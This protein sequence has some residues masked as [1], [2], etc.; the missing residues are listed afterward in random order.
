MKTLCYKEAIMKDKQRI[1]IKVGT[2]TLTYENGKANLRKVEKLCKVISDLENQGHEMVLVSSG[3]LGVGMGK[4][5]ITTRPT[6]TNKKQAI[7]AVGQCE[8]MFMY[9]KFFDE[10]NNVVS[11]ILLTKYVVETPHKEETVRN[12]FMSLI[13]M[14]IIPIVNEND[15]VA[16]DELEGNKIG[17][18]DQ[19]SAIVA[20]IIN[21]DKLIILTDIDGLYDKNPAT[22]SD[23]KKIN[24][25]EL[26]TDEIKAMAG[27]RGSSRGTGGMATKILAAEIATEVGIDVQ[28]ISGEN[29]E[30]IYDVFEG[31]PVGTIFMGKEKDNDCN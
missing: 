6:E 30:T 10:Y 25:V 21:A 2:S 31:K 22:N 3:A 16:T 18:N 28:I 26:I 11:Q 15:S 17:D 23:A 4:L 27:G 13:D 1:V 29:P 7:A 9:D 19:L 14:G 20:K 24:T 8:L 5:G 12:T